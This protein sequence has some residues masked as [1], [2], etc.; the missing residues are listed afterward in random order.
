MHYRFVLEGSTAGAGGVIELPDFA[1]M[2]TVLV[3]G[4]QLVPGNNVRWIGQ[5]TLPV[6]LPAGALAAWRERFAAAAFTCPLC[7]ATSHHPQDLE[8]RFCGR[9]DMFVDDV[10][11]ARGA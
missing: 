9:C 11:R 8:H 4:E 7:G 6:W 1:T 2:A 10:L 3:D 5:D